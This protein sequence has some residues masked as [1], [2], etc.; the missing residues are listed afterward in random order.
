MLKVLCLLAWTGIQISSAL[1]LTTHFLNAQDLLYQ[2]DNVVKNADVL[3]EDFKT[4]NDKLAKA[5]NT[6]DKIRILEESIARQKGM[7]G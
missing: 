1:Y 6:D 2:H 4:V 5:K 3:H 7:I